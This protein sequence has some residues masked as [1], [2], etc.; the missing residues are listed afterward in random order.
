[1]DP[2]R[3][4][5]ETKMEPPL[6]DPSG[7]WTGRGK[8][9]R[10]S[11]APGLTSSFPTFFARS[12]HPHVGAAGGGRTE[13]RRACLSALKWPCPHPPQRWAGPAAVGLTLCQLPGDPQCKKGGGARASQ[14]PPRVQQTRRTQSACEQGGGGGSFQG[15][16]GS[17]LGQLPF[18]ICA[19]DLEGAA[20]AV[21]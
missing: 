10:A 21:T 12:R 11:L 6:L 19:R 1:M 16:L 5:V 4:T 7:P 9:A 15:P 3:E 2:I 18:L 17:A 20:R 8:G 14:S 13:G